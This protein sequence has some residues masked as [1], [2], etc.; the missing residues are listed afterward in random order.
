MSKEY[1]ISVTRVKGLLTARLTSDG[2]VI[3][4]GR[5]FD[6]L[7]V[8]SDV[9][10][11]GAVVEVRDGRMGRVVG[12]VHLFSFDVLVRA[13]DVGDCEGVSACILADFLQRAPR[14]TRED[15]ESRLVPWVTESDAGASFE[16]EDLD[17]LSRH[18]ERDGN[19]EESAL[20][21]TIEAFQSESVPYSDGRGTIGSAANV[22]GN[23]G[24]GREHTRD[25]LAHS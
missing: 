22:L 10:L 18:I 21:L 17:I 9:K 5:E 23:N 8:A 14:L 20:S 6:C 7:D 11:F 13:V 25:S 4:V 1:S 15:G 24:R 2:D 3:I 12:T 16:S 19:G